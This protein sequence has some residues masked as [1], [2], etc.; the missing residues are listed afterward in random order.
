MRVHSTSVCL[1]ILCFFGSLGT[2]NGCDL[3][4]QKPSGKSMDPYP[5]ATMDAVGA[6][7]DSVV[8]MY[9]GWFLGVGLGHQYTIGENILNDDADVFGDIAGKSITTIKSNVS[10]F[11][12][13]LC[14]GYG[15]FVWDKNC[16]VGGEFTLDIQGS[17]R[18]SV[19]FMRDSYNLVDRIN[20]LL[21]YSRQQY[22]TSSFI[23][24]LA[25]NIGGYIRP[26]NTLFYTRIGLTIF[27]SKSGCGAIDAG[28]IIKDKKVTPIVGFGLEKRIVGNCSLKMEG[29]YRFSSAVKASKIESAV[30]NDGRLLTLGVY[31]K[32]RTKGYAVRLMCTYHFRK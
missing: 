10:R 6:S 3:A 7:K 19:Y 31:H 8:R 18:R 28:R 17:S 22:K 32:S 5:F 16:Y 21:I 4:P 1:V 29:D 11:G 23:P 27:G 24:T 25:T 2:M 9:A 20:D 14:G 15:T 12:A 30:A 13:S 26:L